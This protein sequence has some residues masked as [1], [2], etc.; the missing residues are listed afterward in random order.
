MSVWLPYSYTR[1]V[2]AEQRW[3]SS[4]LAIGA[5]GTQVLRFRER[6]T[7]EN[8]ETGEAEVKPKRNWKANAKRVRRSVGFM[9]SGEER[10]ASSAAGLMR[11]RLRDWWSMAVL[12]FSS[13]IIILWKWS[14]ESTKL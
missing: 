3:S 14:Q 8:M 5:A 4:R 11:W 7:A 6:V 1:S 2:D 13:L 10:F 12:R 9:L